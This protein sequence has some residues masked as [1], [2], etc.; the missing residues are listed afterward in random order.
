RLQHDLRPGPG[1]AGHGDPASHL[2]RALAHAV[3]AEAGALAARRL[4][5]VEAPA[6]VADAQLH[7]A[8]L[9]GEEHFHDPS[10]RVLEGVRQGFLADAEDVPLDLAA[11]R[12]RRPPDLEPRVEGR[13]RSQ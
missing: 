7:P 4:V 3:E 6:V 12:S 11:E 13:V 9:E 10:L 1:P 2:L 5:R 8:V